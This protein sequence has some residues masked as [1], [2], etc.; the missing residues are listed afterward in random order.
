MAKRRRKQRVARIER[1]EAP[2]ATPGTLCIDPA[3]PRPVL[4]LIAYGKDT[5]VERTIDDLDPL[6]EFLG[7]EAITWL[8]V[9]GLGDVALVRAIGKRFNLHQLTLED[10]VHVHQR[11]KVEHFENY[12]F[13]VVRMVFLDGPELETEQ[14]SIV[15]GKDFVITFQEGRPG[16][17]LEPVRERLRRSRGV[18]RQGGPDYLA[19]AL[20]DAVIDH[21][22]PVLS[23]IAERLD[24]LEDEVLG[25]A[26]LD[27]IWRIHAL[28][29]HLITLRS[30]ILPQRDLVL[31]LINN[32]V[33]LV[34]EETRVYLRDVADHTGQIVDLLETYREASQA[35]IEIH[36]NMA[37]NRMNEVMQLLT[38]VSAIF[39]PLTFV[40]GVYGMN[41]DPDSSPYNMPE[42]RAR[43]GYPI[44]VLVMAAVAFGLLFLFYKRGWIGGGG[45]RRR[46]P[47]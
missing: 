32:P 7:K 11:A 42:L 35:L 28:K 27:I 8:N 2:G 19:Y 47:R 23:A 17:C 33:P 26:N 22:F 16:D 38:I 30:S 46:P 37:S 15:I 44:T 41:F 14:L 29:R 34:R 1:P 12:V 39:V 6:E 13:V 10:V 36:L 9:D 31:S 24:G 4:E 40:V 25:Q 20:I 18:I 45:P 5:L 43:Y 21:Y 3:A